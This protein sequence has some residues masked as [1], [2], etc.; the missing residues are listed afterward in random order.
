MTAVS[1]TCWDFT[2]FRVADKVLLSDVVVFGNAASNN[3]FLSIEIGPF[4]SK[5]TNLAKAGLYPKRPGDLENS[6]HLLVAHLSLDFPL[7]HGSQ[8]AEGPT[9]ENDIIDSLVRY[10]PT[11]GEWSCVHEDVYLARNA[12]LDGRGGCPFPP[13]VNTVALHQ[14]VFLPITILFRATKYPSGDYTLTKHRVNQVRAVNEVA[15]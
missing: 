13:T 6:R 15:F 10:H 3:L 2:P 5:D 7:V 1:G 12:F 14:D 4:L 9:S 11:P 8:I